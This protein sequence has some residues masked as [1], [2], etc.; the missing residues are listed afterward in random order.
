[1]RTMMIIITAA[2]FAW[3]FTEAAKAVRESGVK[4]E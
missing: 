4:I 1:M 2:A 3:A